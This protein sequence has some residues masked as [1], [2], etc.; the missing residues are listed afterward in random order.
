MSFM[1]AEYNDFMEQV[2]LEGV[3][4]DE[5]VETMRSALEAFKKT[6]SW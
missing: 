4:S 5:V 3:Y 6:Q 2:N 1:K